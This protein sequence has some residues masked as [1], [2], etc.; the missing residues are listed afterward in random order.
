L[1]DELLTL[2]IATYHA[3]LPQVLKAKYN[4]EIV[5]QTDDALPTVLE[6]LFKRRSR[7]PY[8]EIGQDRT[9]MKM[10][11]EHLNSADLALRYIVK[12]RAK[13]KY[14]TYVEPQSLEK[15]REAKETISPRAHK[16]AAIIDF[17]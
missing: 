11:Q 7:I 12:D 17:F 4:K 10:L 8:E 14:K 15:L 2:Y 16:Q 6:D 13:K 3:M 5:K 9:L 1:A